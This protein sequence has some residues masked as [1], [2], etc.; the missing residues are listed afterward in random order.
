METAIDISAP[1]AAAWDLLTDTSR[2]PEWGPSVAR[3][4]STDRWIGP[5]S[6][7]RV[8]TAFGLWLPFAVSAFAAGRQWSWKVAGIP[9]TG[10]RVEAL[11]PECC[12]VVFT[13][14][15]L[16]APYLLICRIAARRIKR[17]LEERPH[18]A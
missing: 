7:G 8:C 11:G 1:A 2:W 14:P 18:P 15:A 5:V 13:V 12:R 4:E 17:I 16:A 3:V 9:A 6:T 10:H